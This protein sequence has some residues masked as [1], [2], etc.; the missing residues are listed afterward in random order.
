[1]FLTFSLIFL[2]KISFYL[3]IVNRNSVDILSE[4]QKTLGQCYTT[5]VSA[6]S[7]LS[8]GW[9]PVECW[10][11]ITQV[12]V[13]ISAITR[14]TPR[15]THALVHILSDMRLILNWYLTTIRPT[16]GQYISPIVLDTWLIQSLYWPTYR[17]TQCLQFCKHDPNMIQIHEWKIYSP[18]LLVTAFFVYCLIKYKP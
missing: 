9:I 13:N 11:S 2:L 10:L 17:L 4:Y 16:V 7:R 18:N 15:L 3:K 5:N 1:M 8:I 14:P 6:K 12:L